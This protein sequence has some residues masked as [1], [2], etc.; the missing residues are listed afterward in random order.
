MYKERTPKTGESIPPP[1][2][3]V[4]TISR[5]TGVV[6]GGAPNGDVRRSLPAAGRARARC[7]VAGVGALCLLV[8]LFGA[9]PSG[10]SSTVA[11]TRTAIG[12]A[13]DGPLRVLQS[14]P[15]YFTND[16][17]RAVYLTGSHTWGNFL[18]GGFLG[19]HPVNWD[20]Y[21]NFLQDHN[22]NFIRLWTPDSAADLDTGQGFPRE[23]VHPQ[24][25]VRT[26]PGKALDGQPKFDL[27]RLNQAY[28][29][30]L[31][32]R[33]LAARNRGIY[34]SIMLFDTWGV[35][36]YPGIL[37]PWKGHP[38]NASNNVNGI[39]GD[40]NRTGNGLQTETLKIPRVTALQKAYVRKV[41]NTVNG[42]DNV[43]YE[44]CNE[45]QRPSKN[46]QYNLIHYIKRYEGTKPTQHPVGMTGINGGGPGL[47]N[48]EIFGS[49]ADWISPFD[50]AFAGVPFEDYS[51]N[52]PA[53]TGAKVILSDTDHL[54]NNQP[55][56]LGIG[57]ATDVWVWKSFT[58]GLNPIYMDSLSSLTGITWKDESGAPSVRSAM[59]DTRTYANKMSL[60]AMIPR[61]DLAS[62]QYAL[63][64]PG[65]EYL[66][67]Q[68]GSGD[69]TVDLAARRYHVE[70]FNP[71]TRVTSSG[72]SVTSVGERRSFTPPFGGD[73]V[74]YLKAVGRHGAGIA[75]NC[76]RPR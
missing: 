61:G 29:D 37:G 70:W 73:A 12:S 57:V 55:D 13:I 58:R 8:S 59:G 75:K 45:C 2:L 39:D 51:L 49:P 41:I 68:P 4:R 38:Y 22:Q 11:P 56:S 69:F 54:A 28:F 32:R 16:S 64:A 7:I 3:R 9:V 31:H 36:G 43:L 65:C 52:P 71:A 33:V 23:I 44:I 34:V 26:G 42:L 67:Y 25:Y 53:S 15:R 46:W 76:E 74:L 18:D 5:S 1:G 63:A 72:G 21:L 10:A 20:A 66:V 30:R 19:G 35:G 6:R 27:T 50:G 47:G 17:G 40:P 14:N 60:A 24:V 48:A 62:T